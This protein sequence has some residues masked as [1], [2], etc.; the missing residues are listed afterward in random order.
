[1]KRISVNPRFVNETGDDLIPGKIH[2][3]RSNYDYWKRFKGKELALFTWEGKPYGKGSKQNVFCIKKIVY[4]EKVRYWG[5]CFFRFTNY[6]SI[7]DSEEIARNDGFKTNKDFY[8]WFEE[9][10][11]GFMAIIHFIDFRYKEKK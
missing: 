8:N 9:Y 5:G 11:P 2:T 6:P 10:K 3:I 1:M 4:V 7:I